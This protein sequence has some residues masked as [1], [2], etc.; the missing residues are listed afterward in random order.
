MYVFQISTLPGPTFWSALQFLKFLHLHDNPIGNIEN[1][2]YLSSCLSLTV[3]TMYDTPLSLKR[4]YRHHAVNS[5]WTLKG[6]DN[7]VISDE[8]I[9]EDAEFEERFSALHPSFSIELCPQSLEVSA[10]PS[11]IN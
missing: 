4:N 1:L 6:L 11:Q 5:I 2:Q 3:L 8:E 10:S 9:I 7:F